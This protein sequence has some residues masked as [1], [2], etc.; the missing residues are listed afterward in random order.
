MAIPEAIKASLCAKIR[1]ARR[2]Y[3]KTHDEDDGGL[4]DA[5]YSDEYNAGV[6]WGYY[7]GLQY[8]SKLLNKTIT[9]R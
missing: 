2:E 7:K 3:Y 4:N 6:D 9:K 1:E 8:A 5:G